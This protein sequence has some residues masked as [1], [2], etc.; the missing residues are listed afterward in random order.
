MVFAEEGLPLSYEVFEGNRV[1][2]WTL[3]RWR[4][5][6]YS[7]NVNMASWAA[8]G[9]LIA[10]SSVKRTL[11]RASPESALFPRKAHVARQGILDI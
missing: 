11:V 3:P 6:W 1:D 2:G 9:L 5:S 8:S 10:A 4:K 7:E